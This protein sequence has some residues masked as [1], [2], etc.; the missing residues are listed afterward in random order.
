[1]A[2]S[3]AI[4]GC[5]NGTTFATDQRAKPR[6]VGTFADIGAVEGVFE[7]VFPLVN[8]TPAGNGSVQFGFTNLNGGNFTVLASTNVAAP[9]NTWSNL[10]APTES[11][12]GVFTFTDLAAT[13]H[14]QRFYRVTMP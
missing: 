1:M 5:T 6:I 14:P 8:V 2:G 7:P 9:L 12:V 13:N 3:P 4:N 10:G 11:P